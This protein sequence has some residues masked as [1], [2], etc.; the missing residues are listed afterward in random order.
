[1]DSS[2]AADLTVTS[3]QSETS[4]CEKTRKSASSS[5]PLETAFKQ[6]NDFDSQ[7][8]TSLAR[9]RVLFR[10]GDSGRHTARACA[11]AAKCRRNFKG[12]DPV[13]P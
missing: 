5:R 7:P 9:T 1:M 11:S 8:T 2:Q 3:S 10:T 13:K 6:A 12:Q 4:V